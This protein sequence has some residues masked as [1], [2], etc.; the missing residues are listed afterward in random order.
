MRVLLFFIFDL[1]L[2]LT[3]YCQQTPI[4][5]DTYLK[6]KNYS[7]AALTFKKQ[8]ASTA[9]SNLLKKIGDAYFLSLIHI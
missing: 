6:N 2:I 5:A 8:F 4:S 3:V 7:A 1:L 9:D